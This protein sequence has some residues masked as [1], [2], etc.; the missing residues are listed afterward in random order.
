MRRRP[1]Q[2]DLF[3]AEAPREDLWSVVDSL[4]DRTAK[5]HRERKKLVKPKP[6]Q[7]S[8]LEPEPRPPLDE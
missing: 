1:E 5:A 2:L 8:L 6:R 4:N 7:D 3:S